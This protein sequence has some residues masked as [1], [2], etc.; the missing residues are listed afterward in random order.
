MSSEGNT[1][2]NPVFFP[3]GETQ[4]RTQVINHRSSGACLYKLS[5]TLRVFL[6]FLSLIIPVTMMFSLGSLLNP[7]GINQRKFEGSK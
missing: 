4:E 2:V 7:L 6:P 1:N 5:A 3:H